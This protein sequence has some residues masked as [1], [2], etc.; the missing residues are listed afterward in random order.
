MRAPDTEIQGYTHVYKSLIPDREGD[1]ARETG[2]FLGIP[3]KYLTM[4]E[5]QLFQAWNDPE[6]SWPEPVDNPLFAGFLDCSRIISRD[7]RVLLSGEGNDNL[8]DFQMWPNVKDLRGRGEWWRLLTEL[9]N[10]CWVRPFP[11]RGICARVLGLIGKE[12]D[13]PV[14]PQ[15]LDKDFAR[16]LNLEERW[17]ETRGLPMAPATH[18]IHPRGYASLSLPH[19]THM[20][21]QENPGVTLYPVEVRYPFLD[22]RIV[23]YLLGVPPFP[24]TFEKMLLREAMAGRLPERVRVRPKTPL[25]GDP[26]SAQFQRTGTAQL[27]QMPWSPYSS[28]YIDRSALPKLHGKMDS[29]QMSVNLRPYCLNI[30]LQ[31]ARRVRY[32]LH[33]EAGNG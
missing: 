18:P 6:L 19:W 22:L 11:W 29:Q 12:P 17:K 14:F 8:M 16:R 25:Q 23:N 15:W 4:D 30:W 1:Y 27:D 3:V 20:F 24:W 7:C 9:A 26:L 31:S 5:V 32:K 10:Y 13:Q 33:A 2:E 28:R 21:E